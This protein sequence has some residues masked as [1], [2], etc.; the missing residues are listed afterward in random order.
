MKLIPAFGLA[1]LLSATALPAFAADYVFKVAH[2]NAADEVQDKGLQ[3]MR[4]LLEKK[5]D[6][7]ATI[8]IFP[9]G[10]LGDEAQLVEGTM[11][12][13]LDMAMTANSTISNYITDFRVFDLPFLFTSIPALSEKLEDETVYSAMETSAE[14]AGFELI[15]VFSSGIRHLMTKEPVESIADLQNLKIR[16]MQNPIHVD[17]FRSFGANPTPLAYSELYGALQ[18]GVVDGAEGAATNYTGQK[19]YEVAPD[20][21]ILGWLNMT[22]VVFM[23]EGKFAALPEDIK[24]ALKESGEEASLWQRQYVDDQE[25][26]LLDALVA[27]GVTISHPDPAPFREAVIPLY[28]EMLETD[29][30]KELFKLA[31][32]D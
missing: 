7:R 23:N 16:T 25:K 17:A 29:S 32:Q 19:L 30:Q 13:T 10:V 21:A 22:A 6:G 5:T 26:P 28:E 11:L 9:N 1:A 14:N 15:G 18:S 8:E 31:T 2:T 27:K 3:L 24:V 4:D 20:F 12:G